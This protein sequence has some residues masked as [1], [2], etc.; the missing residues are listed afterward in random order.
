MPYRKEAE[1]FNPFVQGTETVDAVL[2][3]SMN[4]LKVWV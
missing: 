2:V 1:K 3:K 4:D